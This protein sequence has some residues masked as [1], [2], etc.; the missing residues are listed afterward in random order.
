MLAAVSI[1]RQQAGGAS[2][3]PLQLRLGLKV[4]VMLVL[5][6]ERDQFVAPMLLKEQEVMPDEYLEV[7]IEVG[8]SVPLLV[9]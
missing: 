5:D 1:V 8:P 2:Y 3:T 7:D 9:H 6:V 4:V